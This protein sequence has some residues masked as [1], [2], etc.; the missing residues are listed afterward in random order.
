MGK[1]V[2]VA[3]TGLLLAS[4]CGS[5]DTDDSDASAGDGAG[6]AG[7]SAGDR[8][9]VASGAPGSSGASTTAGMAG[10]AAGTPGDELGGAG[11]GGGTPDVAAGGAGGEPSA[12]GGAGGDPAL[13]A[14]FVCVERGT[15]CDTLDDCDVGE[16]CV[17]GACTAGKPIGDPCSGVEYC[18][19]DVRCV[20]ELCT[21]KYSLVGLCGPD[22]QNELD[23]GP[24]PWLACPLGSYCG[25]WGITSAFTGPTCASYEN[26]TDGVNCQ[27]EER[28]AFDHYCQTEGSDDAGY[29]HTC[30][31]RVA[32]GPDRCIGDH[33]DECEAGYVCNWVNSPEEL[34]A[35]EPGDPPLQMVGCVPPGKEG[36]YCSPIYPYTWYHESWLFP[37]QCGPNLYCSDEA[38]PDADPL[39]WDPHGRC[40]PLPEPT[41]DECETTAD[42]ADGEV[43]DEFFLGFMTC[44]IAPQEGATCWPGDRLP[45]AEGLECLLR[46]SFFAPHWGYCT[47]VA[48]LNEGCDANDACANDGACIAQ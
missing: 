4:A 37:S 26:R 44:R 35:H 30:Q 33:P 48:Q 25:F 43:C 34:D 36:D 41:V 27:T 32:P 46:D 29:R 10:A 39:I 19:R 28:C 47:R 1:W 14:P 16:F 12:H 9:I 38:A 42:C 18:G 7:A 2:A 8:A 23:E 11:A 45:C 31:E 21:Y 40:V 5:S 3:L 6:G 24:D 13:P 22:P 20:D 17:E 15:A